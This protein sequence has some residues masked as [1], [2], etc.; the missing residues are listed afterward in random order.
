MPFSI[1]SSYSLWSLSLKFL[2]IHMSNGWTIEGS[3]SEITHRYIFP[4]LTFPFAISVYVLQN[5]LILIFS[6]FYKLNHPVFLTIF[7]KPHLL[8]YYW[9]DFWTALFF[10]NC[11]RYQ[12][13]TICKNCK[14]IY[15]SIFFIT[16]CQLKIL[17]VIWFFDNFLKTNDFLVRSRNF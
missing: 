5:F 6:L 8:L 10:K 4:Y 1:Q 12:L 15:K 3:P 14:Y 16:K 2:L 17:K 11:K 13:Y 9:I 7:S